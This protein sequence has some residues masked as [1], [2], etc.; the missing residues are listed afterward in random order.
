DEPFRNNPA[1]MGDIFVPAAGGRMVRV[2]DV[3]ALT[4]GSAPASI[5]RF[6]RMR[7][8]S[9]NA[10][11]DALKITLGNAIAAARGKVAELGLKAG[12]QVTFGGSA[13]TL[14]QSGNDFVLAIVLAVLFPYIVPASQFYS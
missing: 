4:L 2:S 9:V 10:N 13:K 1:T 7:Q 8:I 14:S 5:D 12:Y 3:A 6:N 11:L